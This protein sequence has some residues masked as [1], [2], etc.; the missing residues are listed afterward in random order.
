LLRLHSGQRFR[1]PG[2][3]HVLITITDDF[4]LL[5][6]SGLVLDF[7]YGANDNIEGVSMLY[8]SGVTSYLR[9]QVWAIVAPE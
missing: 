8:A 3:D 9:A 6:L 4:F 1:L 5:V 7:A 2:C